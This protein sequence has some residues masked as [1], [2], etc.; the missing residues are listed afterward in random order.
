MDLV[1]DA[2]PVF[3]QLHR[4]YPREPA[5]LYG[6]AAAHWRKGEIAETTRLMNQYRHT[7]TAR[8]FRLV[9]IGCSIASPGT[10]FRGTGGAA[11][12]S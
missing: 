11:T 3:E 9:L 8:P 6:L 7:A 10:N 2:L 1:L 12:E 5:Y 4:D